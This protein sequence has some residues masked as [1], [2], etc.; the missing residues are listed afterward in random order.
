[1]KKEIL[2]IGGGSAGWMAAAYFSVKPQYSV[3]LVESKNVPIIGVGE[4]TVPSV[5]D[6]VETVGLTE[7]DLLDGCNAVRK[8]SIQH[9]NWCGNNTQWWHHFCL[10]E[11]EH[12]E[13]IFWMENNIF[14]IKKWRHAY[15]LDAGLLGSTIRD[16]VA[17]KNGV[18]HII[19]DIVDV[20]IDENGVKFIKGMQSNYSA[21]LYIDCTGFK[22]LVRGKFNTNKKFHN[23][24]IN[25]C[26][27][28]GPSVFSEE[29]PGYRYTQTFTMDYGWRWRISL[30]NRAGNG[31]VFCKDAVSIDQAADEF[32]KKTPGIIKDKVTVVPFEN[33]YETDPWYK[34]V[35]SIGLSCGFLEPL[36]STGLFLAYGPVKLIDKLLEDKN[37]QE[38]FNRVWRNLYSQVGNFV[39][40]HYSTSTLS[41]TDY[42]R[43]FNRVSEVKLPL[44]K[45]PIFDR[46][47]FRLLAKSRGIPYR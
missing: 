4:S 16:K 41:H 46:Y 9:N 29:F 25:N 34:N 17:I 36:E 3:T 38:K 12:D 45:K 20:A 39:S 42:W 27:I 31:Y 37:R 28:A 19:D 14:P 2:I 7:Q 1:M 23:N 13:Q 21:D 10:D 11:S 33:S 44:T 15:H 26:A 5:L 40:L 6:F 18:K 8:Y 24:L 30:Q 22:K 47:S 35:V 32:I 43:S